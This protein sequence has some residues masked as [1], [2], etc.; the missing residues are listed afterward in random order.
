MS[1]LVQLE[2]IVD[3]QGI[4]RRSIAGINSRRA[5][6]IVR[7]RIIIV[8]AVF[9]FLAR[10]QRPPLAVE[11]IPQFRRPRGQA[12]AFDFAQRVIV[13]GRARVTQLPVDGG[14]TFDARG[15]NRQRTA[16]DDVE[17]VVG[18]CAYSEPTPLGEACRAQP[19][20]ATAT[21]NVKMCNPARMRSSLSSVTA[22]LYF[23]RRGTT[24]GWSNCW[25][26]ARR[27]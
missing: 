23:H 16:I 22:F 2:R 7:Q 20:V 5:Q 18:Q 17:H 9:G 14:Q 4:R 26:L 8:R 25:G 27:A 19:V 24:A 11:E 13:A 15:V 1:I 21:I 12:L 6:N 10:G 3:V